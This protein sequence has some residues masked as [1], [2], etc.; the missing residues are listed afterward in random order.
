MVYYWL[1]CLL[2][3]HFIVAMKTIQKGASDLSL[4]LG[5]ALKYVGGVALFLMAV[6]GTL[7]VDLVL[8]AYAEKKG[9]AFLTGFILGSM[10]SGGS[11]NPLPLLIASP[12]TSAIAVGLSFALGVSGVGL[13]ILAGWAAAATLFLIGVG[14]EALGKA[15][16]PEEAGY[17]QPG[18]FA[19]R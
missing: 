13:F 6:V 3:G 16:D 8:L 18:S 4:I 7:S 15:M 1:L 9:N 14:L 11:T 19:Y 5:V 10:F 2:R 17:D 12:I